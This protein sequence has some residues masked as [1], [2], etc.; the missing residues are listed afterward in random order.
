[1]RKVVAG[2]LI[3]SITAF[4]AIAG[5]ISLEQFI[6]GNFRSGLLWL[7]ICQ[8]IDGFDGPIARKIDIHLH[9]TRFDG[10]ILDLVV[11][12]VTCVMV[13]VAML[14]RLDLI[15]SEFSW[16]YVGLVIFTGALWFARTDQETEDHWFNGFPA[17]WNLVIPT[18]LILGTRESYIQIIILALSFLS[19]TKLKFPHLVKVQFLRPLTWSLAIIYFVAL[20]A[21]SIKY[22]DGPAALKPILVIFP[23][24][25]FAISSY[26]SWKV[27]NKG[28]NSHND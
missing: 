8:L 23:L 9:A 7:I 26:H 5:L 19:L 11:D 17:A 10:H 14:I 15:T 24:Y 13:P 20:T 4:G 3:H 28:V 27:R 1:V 6:N 21:L 22:P 16:L 25:I 18:F 12:Y 2:Y